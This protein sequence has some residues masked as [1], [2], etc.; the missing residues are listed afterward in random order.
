MKELLGKIVIGNRAPD[1]MPPFHEF[2]EIAL[3]RNL[4]MIQIAVTDTAYANSVIK[5]WMFFG[6][7]APP[8][9][10]ESTMALF[11][12]DAN[13][14]TSYNVCYTK[15]LRNFTLVKRHGVKLLS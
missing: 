2:G 10:K 11:L 7:G 8:P 12:K 4:K 13:R 3:D 5:V 15:L 9:D 14:I 6:K 1:P